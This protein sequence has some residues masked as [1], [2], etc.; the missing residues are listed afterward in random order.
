MAFNRG[1]FKVLQLGR[2]NP[3]HHQNML[4]NILAEK[5]LGVLVDSKLS[6]GQRCA[7]ASKKVTGILGV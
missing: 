6:I 5:D 1:K 3:R 7:L 4:E 2:N